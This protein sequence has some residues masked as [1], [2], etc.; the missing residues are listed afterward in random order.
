MTQ[1]LI[2]TPEPLILVEMKGNLDRRI[3]HICVSRHRS[4]DE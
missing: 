1:Q 3:F 2:T 4:V